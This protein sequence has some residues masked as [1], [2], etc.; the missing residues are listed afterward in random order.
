MEVAG[1]QGPV[2]RSRFNDKP[3]E[4]G[5]TLAEFLANFADELEKL[6]LRA[7]VLEFVPGF[8]KLRELG[9]SPV[10][11]G[12]SP[13][14]RDRIIAY[15]LRYPRT[16]IDGD[17]LMVVSGTNGW[18]RHVRDLRVK[19]GWAIFSGGT[20]VEMADGDPLETAGIEAA[21]GVHPSKIKPNQYV[22]TG[23][24]QDPNAPRRWRFLIESRGRK[25]R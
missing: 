1:T 12:D 19:F 14:A 10:S 23:T 7:K 4:I 5:R 3:E 15:F 11:K 9:I 20:L 17:E 13:S 24:K 6:D 25:R 16:M 22:L 2:R 8:H 21:L 18:A